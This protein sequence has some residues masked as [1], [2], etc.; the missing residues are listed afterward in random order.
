MD[1]IP[2]GF[3]LF[4]SAFRG[5]TG[6]ISNYTIALAIP[7]ATTLSVKTVKQLVAKQQGK[8]VYR[9]VNNTVEATANATDEA[10]RELLTKYLAQGDISQEAYNQLI[11][12]QGKELSDGLIKALDDEYDRFYKALSDNAG[13]GV[14]GV[15]KF[16]A[17]SGTELKTHLDDL[18]TLPVG[19]PYNG[20]FFKSMMKSEF[21]PPGANTNPKLI[22]DF[23]TQNLDHRYSKIGESGYYVSKSNDGNIIEMGFN[24]GNDVSKYNRYKFEN[25]TIDNMLDLTDDAVRQQLGVTEEMIKKLGEGK[26]EYTHVLGTWAKENYKGIIYPG[27][28]G[29]NYINIIIF[30][31]VDVDNALNSLTPIP[32]N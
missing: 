8:N 22:D 14:Q 17:K 30:K 6:N 25:V 16:I 5:N 4:Y 9:I 20:Q 21:L 13:A 24:T 18:V 26:Y 10:A 3:G 12:K 31:Q 27:A 29:G 15:G 11:N 19:K 1:A 32:L 7:A 2:D 28:Q 23:A